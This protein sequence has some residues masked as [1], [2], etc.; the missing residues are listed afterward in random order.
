VPAVRAR[1]D[2]VD[3]ALL[4]ALK[5]GAV[6]IARLEHARVDERGTHVADG[7]ARV[8]VA[9]RDVQRAMGDRDLTAEQRLQ[10]RQRRRLQP[11]QRRRGVVGIGQRREV[12]RE[13]RGGV[14]LAGRGE[15]RDALAQATGVAE[16]SR[17]REAVALHVGDRRTQRRR[18]GGWRQR[19]DLR[20]AE[21]GFQ[22]KVRARP[23]GRNRTGVPPRLQLLLGRRAGGPYADVRALP[24]A[25]AVPQRQ[26][27]AKPG[28]VRRGLVLQADEQLVSQA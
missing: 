14:R 11:A 15:L 17:P 21:D 5:R 25:H 8:L 12:R 3:G 1:R 16:L 13:H 27:R 18:L 19:I 23:I 2:S 28:D 9:R 10:Q 26:P 20:R 6:L 22:A 7:T 4:P 24:L